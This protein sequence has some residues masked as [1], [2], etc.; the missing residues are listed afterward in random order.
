MEKM[1]FILMKD[2][3]IVGGGISGLYL[4]DKLKLKYKDVTLFEQKDALGGR[5]KTIKNKGVAS[6]EELREICLESGVKMIGF[7]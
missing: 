4:A 2:I 5:V 1:F 6:I 3:V 7:R